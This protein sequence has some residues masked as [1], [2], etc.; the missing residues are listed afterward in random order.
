MAAMFIAENEGF[1]NITREAIAQKGGVSTGAVS[2]AFGTM[3]KLKRTVMRHAIQDEVLSIIA[4]G[5]G[6]RDKTAMKADSHIKKKALQTL[7]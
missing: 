6:V 3:I 2:N 7:M 4:D 1:N 5:L